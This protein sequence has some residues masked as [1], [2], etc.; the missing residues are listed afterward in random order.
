MNSR[1]AAALAAAA[2]AFALADCAQNPVTGHPNFVTMSESQEIQIGREEDVKVRQ[3]Y[4]VYDDKAL[5][6][7]VNE[8]GQRLARASHR[9][10]L[11]YEY[12]VIDSP[13]VNAFALPGG[14]IYI[15]R[16]ILA[17]LG[18]EAELAAVLGHETGH[19]NARHSVQQISAATAAN[20]GASVLQIFVPALQN[21]LGSNA[22]N[23]L[24]NALLSGYGRE[25]EL[26]ADK[27]GA[28][29]LYRTGYDPQAMIKV[30]DVL[31]YQEQFDAE[32]AKTDG[33]EPRAYH[34]L[35][36]SHPDADTRLQE[37][38]AQAGRLPPGSSR[39]NSEE[40][41]HH[42]DKLV[43]GDSPAQGVVRRGNFYH[44]ELGLALTFPHNWR[45]KNQPD[46]VSATSAGNDAIVEL[47][48]A[49]RAQGTPLEV[50]RKMLDGNVGSEVTQTMI[51]GLP[52]A[53]TTTR[54]RGMPTRAA[55][56][57]L[58]RNAYLLA[59][60]GQSERAMQGARADI[61]STVASFRALN[62]DERKLA[63]PLT[64]R[65]I[66]APPGKTFGDLARDSPLGRNAV[67]YLRLLNGLYPNGEPVAGQALKVIE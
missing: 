59:G 37:V 13:E 1:V 56:I 16:G 55:V 64:L 9:P 2:L 63:R 21:S 8:V 38:V 33:R 3:Q 25:H 22:I 48:T 53:L 66:N 40:F 30:L 60:Q 24:G 12:I 51:N 28:E 23:L 10:N 17:Y 54:I 47:R 5:Q 42:I 36:A 41:L 35:F 32:V 46:R 45:I 4:G 67:S 26:E 11:H 7:Y 29:Y 27:L 65:I 57:F 6:Q 31:K 18:S 39:V 34:G 19:V 49:G 15:A 52:A 20:V 14:Y 43:F 61:D 50:L 58:G 44:T 62:E